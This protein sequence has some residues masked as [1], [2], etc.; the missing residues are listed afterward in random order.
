MTI[1]VPENIAD[2]RDYSPMPK[3]YEPARKHGKYI[4][5]D[6]GA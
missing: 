6:G 1:K 5:V 2:V 4:L 3:V